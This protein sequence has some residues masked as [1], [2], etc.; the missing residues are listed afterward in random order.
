MEFVPLLSGADG[1][2]TDVET[3][4]SVARIYNTL[5]DGSNGSTADRKAVVEV[6]EAMPDAANAVKE[7]RSFI[8]RVVRYMIGQGINQFI[9]IGSGFLTDDSIHALAANSIDP[10]MSV[11]V[12]Y[13]D[14][15]PAVVE[16]GNKFLGAIKTA[17]IICADIRQPQDVF[18]NPDLTHLID[19]SQPVGILMMF[20][21]CFLEDKEIVRVMSFIRSTIC[22]GSYVAVTH[23]TLDGHEDR[24]EKEKITK[25][26]EVYA[27]T[28]T[29]L[30][31]RSHKEVAKI[32][33]DLQLVEPGLVFPDQWRIESDLPAL[34]PTKWFYGGLAKKISSPLPSPAR[35]SQIYVNPMK[36]WT[37]FN[38]AALGGTS[39]VVILWYFITFLA[40]SFMEAASVSVQELGDVVDD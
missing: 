33:Q 9:D 35:N 14:R 31:F 6:Q 36:L 7:N 38:Q 37:S 34:E 29:K 30:H 20:V 26:Q 19:F 21:A 13:V 11:N 25:V 5:L 24:S 23:D 2:T 4:T 40:Q 10:A 27:N 16:E 12:V 1:K 3:E 22:D 8:R 17:T 18:T 15:D 28:S 32:L 39:F